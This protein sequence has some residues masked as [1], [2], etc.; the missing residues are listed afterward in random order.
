MG[1]PKN[2]QQQFQIQGN[3]KEE[4]PYN[5]NQETIQPQG[6]KQKN[7]KVIACISGCLLLIILIMVGA[8]FG[9]F[10]LGK[11]MFEGS[12]EASRNITNYL[13]LISSNNISDAYD[14]TSKDFKK[15]FPEQKF[16]EMMSSYEYEPRFK[17]F[18]SQRLT[19]I[20]INQTND[21]K[22]YIYSGEITYDDGD[23]G[24]LNATLIREGDEA[25]IQE[26]D[27][28]VGWERTKKFRN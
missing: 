13:E 23:K 3:L 1:E 22:I 9:F 14:L 27:V 6:K 24:Q 28:K 4:Q 2:T 10:S 20:K 8:G 18:K 7:K 12:K 16:S 19:S 17:H 25:K 26:I 21:K 11:V 5:Q 15:E